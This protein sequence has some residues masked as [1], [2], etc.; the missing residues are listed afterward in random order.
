M[1]QEQRSRI[2]DCKEASK[3]CKLSSSSSIIYLY[4]I[5]YNKATMIF[6]FKNNYESVWS[7][8]LCKTET[9][10]KLQIK[11]LNFILKYL[12]SIFYKL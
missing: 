2:K 4:K 7:I 10:D 8:Y 9:Q 1:K 3:I 12:Y 6:Y 11:L 5:D